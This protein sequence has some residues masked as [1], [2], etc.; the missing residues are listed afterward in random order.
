MAETTLTWK[1]VTG[2]QQLPVA[3]VNLSVAPIE[4][5]F[6]GPMASCEPSKNELLQKH[7]PN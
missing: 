1:H 5:L 3:A 7:A 2:A 6:V 4:C